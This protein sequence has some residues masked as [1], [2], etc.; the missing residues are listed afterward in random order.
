MF[1][2]HCGK[3]L[4]DSSQFCQSCGQPQGVQ[5]GV[6][7]LGRRFANYFLDA[8][9]AG[10]LNFAVAMFVIS[11][12]QYGSAYFL[13]WGTSLLYYIV[14]E[15]IWQRTP[16]KWITGTKVVTKDGRQPSFGKIVGRSFCRL[17]PFNALSILFG[18]PV[19]WHDSIPGVYVVPAE[20][21]PEQVQQI[22]PAV[23]RGSKGRTIFIIIA[24]S[25]IGIA[26]VG[27]LSSVVLLSLNSARGKSRDAKRVADVRQLGSALDL[28]YNDKTKY[29][30][31]LEEL[32]PAY[33]PYPAT[34]PTPADGNCTPELN[35][36]TYH[37][38]GSSYTVTFCLGGDTGGYSAGKHVLTPNGM[39]AKGAEAS[40]NTT[41]NT[42]DAV[43]QADFEEGYKAGYV[44]GRGKAAKLWD[45]F[46]PPATEVRKESYTSGY[47]DGFS[48]GCHE[49]SFTD[50]QQVDSYITSLHSTT[51]SQVH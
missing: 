29:P 4:Q 10:I 51:P 19:A 17:I 42:Y 30:Q 27:L 33:L 31:T 32:T 35:T 18:A 11:N 34:A 8:I 7:S 28:Y 9:F 48:K 49:G 5:Y 12:D 25:V 6:S 36:Y 45:T 41:K 26:I 39:D 43:Q 24:I 47:L 20:Y 3:E 1:C 50:C 38:T 40:T 44:D 13:G 14:F 2:Q 21:T 37:S 22:N 16:G 46:N 23:Q 15:G